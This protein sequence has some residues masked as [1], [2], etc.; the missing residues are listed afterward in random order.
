MCLEPP[1]VSVKLPLGRN[2]GAE[3]S[4][5]KPDIMHNSFAWALGFIVRMCMSPPKTYHMAVRRINST[6]FSHDLFRD[7]RNRNTEPIVGRQQHQ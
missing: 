6:K 7:I 4:F 3:V 1:G 5:R 2:N